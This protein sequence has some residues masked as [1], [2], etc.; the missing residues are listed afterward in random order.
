MVW[1]EQSTG[2]PTI[3]VPAAH[4][5][6]EPLDERSKFLFQENNLKKKL[7]ETNLRHSKVIL[8]QSGIRAGSKKR[9]E[10]QV[11]LHL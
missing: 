3:W 1:K 2:G 11:I 8:M 7:G 4:M 9:G 5:T 10:T 6:G